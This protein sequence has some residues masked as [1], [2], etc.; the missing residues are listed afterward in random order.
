MYNGMTGNIGF[1]GTPRTQMTSKGPMRLLPIA[2]YE[3]N[4]TTGTSQRWSLSIWGNAADTAAEI[5]KVG[6]FIEVKGSAEIKH[7]TDRFGN[8]RIAYNFNTR[9]FN[10]LERKEP[11]PAAAPAVTEQKTDFV[12]SLPIHGTMPGMED[13]EQYVLE[14]VAQNAQGSEPA[15]TELPW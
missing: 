4:H 15:E 9:G 3:N 6:D 10:K 7:Y 2:L 13:P 1:I 8:E 5:L 14:P 11:A 12:A